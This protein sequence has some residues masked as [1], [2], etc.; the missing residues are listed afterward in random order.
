MIGKGRV[1]VIEDVLDTDA[2]AKEIMPA[3]EVLKKFNLNSCNTGS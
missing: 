2:S 1:Q 3:D